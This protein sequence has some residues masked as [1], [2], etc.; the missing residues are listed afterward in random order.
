M[1][2][3]Q[4]MRM[5]NLREREGVLE[6]EKEIWRRLQSS[7]QRGVTEV[8]GSAGQTQSKFGR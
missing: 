8:R 1:S 2:S 3:W 6:R 5:T 7:G 4:F